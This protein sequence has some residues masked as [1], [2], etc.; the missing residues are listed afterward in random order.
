M[1]YFIMC[2]KYQILNI[3]HS[4]HCAKGQ[5]RPHGHTATSHHYDKLLLTFRA[6]CTAF[7]NIQEVTMLPQITRFH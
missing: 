1:F 2:H 6:H 3:Y 5:Q 7:N 4:N